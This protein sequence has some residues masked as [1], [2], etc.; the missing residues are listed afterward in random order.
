MGR[1]TT[2][3]G[4]A[5][6]FP[7]VDTVNQ[8]I[9]VSARPRDQLQS[10]VTRFTE[11]KNAFTQLTVLTVGLQLTGTRLGSAA[12]FSQR[13]ATSSAEN[14]LT[15]TVNSGTTPA[16]GQFNLTPIQTAQSQQLQ[17]SRFASK[18]AAVGAGSFS[19][20]FG[21]FVDPAMVLDEIGGGAGFTRGKIRITD[22]SG[23][24]AEID[25]TY[26]RT[27][28]DVLATINNTSNLG[29][30][31]EAVGD[32]LRLVDTTGD[33]AANLQVQE[34]GGG[35]TAASLGLAGINVAANSATGSDLVS[36]FDN[37]SLERLNDG[38]GVR[39]DTVLP[40]LKINFRDGT[41]ATLDLRKLAVIGTKATAETPATNGT[42]AQVNFT[43]VKGGAAYD[44][45]VIRF[46]DN[47][48]IVKGGETVAYD[49][50]NPA[51]KTLTFQIRE[52]QTSASD[53]VTA[54]NSDTVTNKVFTAGLPTGSGGTGL[55]SVEDTIITSG[56]A[57]T[58]P[59]PAGNESTLGDILNALNSLD[60]T[61][62]S[63][64]ISG[65][66]KRIEL[67]DLSADNGGTFSVEDLHGSQ[68]A[69]DLGLTA[70]AVGDTLTGTRIIGGLKT[71][72]LASL[73]G[74]QGFG[75][76]GSLDLTDRSGATANVDLSSANTLDDVIEAINNAGLG[77][78]AAVNAARN[79]I[80]V[81]DI[82]GQTASNLIIASADANETA[83]KL[84]L[85]V[86]A[87]ITTQASG[88]LHRK[89][90]NE[91]TSLSQLNGGQGITRGSFRI[92][93]TNG[94]QA[95]V[96]IGDNVKTVGDA[97]DAIK[98]AGLAISAR[99][100]DTGDGILLY[101]TAHGSSTLT[102]QEIGGT[103]AKSLRLTGAVQTVDIEGTPTQV[104]DASFNNTI[105]ISAT[106]TL[107]DVAQKINDLGAGVSAA[108][109]NDGSSVMPYRLTLLNQRS[110]SEHSILVDTTAAGFSFTETVKAR[111]ALLAVGDVAG[112]SG[113]LVSSS[114]N[115]F[116]EAV[117][118][119]TININAASTT[120]VTVSVNSS[121]DSFT[122]AVKQFV[123]SYNNL[124]KKI[125]ELTSYDAETD[126]SALLQGDGTMLRLQSDLTRLFSG[127][128]QGA[129][130]IGSLETLGISFKDDGTLALDEGKL[131]A[132]FAESPD[133][134]QQFFTQS[135]TGLSARVKSLGDQLAGVGNSLLIGRSLTIDSRLVILQDRIA[136]YNERLDRE[137]E[138][139]LAKFYASEV[140]ISKLQNN[141]NFLQ[142]L[143]QI[144]D[145][146]G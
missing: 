16:L 102:V 77:V 106:D 90:V 120:A 46:V 53:I 109:I 38:L 132:K 15:A 141:T 145:S 5:T 47:P 69:I 99:I 86:D 82:T 129:G 93:D 44:D 20:G 28:D 66:G 121:T 24:S 117:P 7:I 17:S 70:A 71:T 22:R 74:G 133:D 25:L 139:L 19:F 12:L 119:L 113:Y 89:T 80:V 21:G 107:E 31:A 52:G 3:V 92:I 135:T 140:A 87:A 118:D 13:K 126:K 110:G 40:D 79:G 78:N 98:D 18:T 48:N 122:S 11:Q 59:E 33:T 91:N 138:R 144:A 124:T 116:R 49:D 136:F 37:L 127:R 8:L 27:I 60:P 94:N 128:I 9:Q 103:T 143:Q 34:V 41:D 6:G 134:V 115:T 130:T 125:Q 95:T 104:V 96:I 55:I 29:V 32:Q 61:R 56:G 65:D 26:A 67:T 108:I 54:L 50:S 81:T 101:D 1:I 146:F 123:D 63:A 51:L 42:T 30:R 88:P 114:S 4:L 35:T 73:N 72:L 97:L 137:R 58:E 105:D 64:A 45:V 62:L 76:L 112:G 39:F 68:V 85:V 100:N 10:Q 75:T 2:S 23:T 83:E 57:V 14:L 131:Q 111:D 142:T 43:A 84:G 36:L